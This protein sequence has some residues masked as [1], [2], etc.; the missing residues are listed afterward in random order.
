MRRDRVRL[1]IEILRAI[2]E[3]QDRPPGLARH[4]LDI[5]PGNP[6]APTR[7]QRF[8]GGFLCGKAR[9]I[10]LSGD[11]TAAIAVRT[12]GHR[13]NAFCKPRRALDGRAHPS[14]F[15]NVYADRDD[16]G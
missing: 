1:F 13:V 12:L 16:H 15:D 9:G 5:L 2:I 14:N 10:M 11:N 6:V 4:H 3:L 7:A 8:Q